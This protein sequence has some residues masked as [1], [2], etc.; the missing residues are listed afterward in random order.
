MPTNMLITDG[1]NILNT[2][3]QALFMFTS[4]LVYFVRVSLYTTT[5]TSFISTSLLFNDETVKK[6]MF[7]TLHG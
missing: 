4:V 5:Y 3:Q 6:V 7:R 1:W 2:N